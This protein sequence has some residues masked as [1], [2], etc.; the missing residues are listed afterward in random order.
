MLGE[1]EKGLTSL[2][3]IRLIPVAL[4]L[5]AASAGTASAQFYDDDGFF[6]FVDAAFTTPSNTDQ[7]VA[8]TFGN[9]FAGPGSTETVTQQ[10]TDWGT[11]PTAQLQFG[12]RWLNGS[13]VSISYWQFDDDE[14]VAGEA[15]Y[16]DFTNFT[17]GPAMFL[18]GSYF[19]TYGVP[20]SWDFGS[21]LK[22]STIDIA[23]DK[24]FEATDN[25]VLDWS[26]GIRFASFEETLSG[27]YDYYSSA[28]GF[29]FPGYYSYAADKSNDGSMFGFRAG[30]RADYYFN[31]S[32]SLDGGL[33]WSYLDGSVESRSTLAPSGSCNTT[34]TP[35]GPCGGAFPFPVELPTATFYIDDD[36]SGNILDFDL[37]VV[38]HIADDRYRVRF[39]YYHSRWDGIA[40]DLSRNLP[41][42]FATL[43][44][45]ES[46]SFSGFRIGVGF[47]F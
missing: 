40:A 24:Q 23:W 9:A 30:V 34:A 27:S 16:N 38:W 28:Y 32:I 39:G 7:V 47:L 22:A 3:R 10:M 46:V 1:K 44:S 33:G 21:N 11:S 18:G 41:G 6:L 25:L 12:Y 2:R 20:G 14:R 43:D 35:P 37:N 8:E 29:Y 15:G 4:A 5:L 13:A 42:T 31:D 17:I 26:L 19:G 45:R 36:R